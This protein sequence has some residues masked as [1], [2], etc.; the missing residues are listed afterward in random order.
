MKTERLKWFCHTNL[1]KCVVASS[2]TFYFSNEGI[3]NAALISLET[4][5]HVGTVVGDP[6]SFGLVGGESFFAFFTYDTATLPA[7]P[8]ADQTYYIQT[9]S[10]NV[11][12]AGHQFTGNDWFVFMSND[13]FG[14]FF[15][16]S[17]GSYPAGFGT[18]AIDGIPKP[19][20]GF[21]F[22]AQDT[23]AS[24]FTDVALPVSPFPPLSAFD[25]RNLGI[26]SDNSLGQTAETFDVT[27]TGLREIPEPA[28]FT[29]LVVSL[30]VFAV[31][32]RRKHPRPQGV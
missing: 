29:L 24:I 14:D 9:T 11:T 2:I 22:G 21:T 16:L 25:V 3:S 17:A 5:G 15:E 13:T 7:V 31:S 23:T 10:Y 30:I 32:M 1:L 12:V 27:L 18:V 20:V 6:F 4:S 26:F 8:R 19:D 28:T